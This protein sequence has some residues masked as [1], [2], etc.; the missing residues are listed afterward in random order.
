MAVKKTTLHPQGDNTTD[1][2]P[3]TSIDQV[4]GYVELNLRNGTNNGVEGGTSVSEGEYSF[5]FGFNSHTYSDWCVSM[6]KNC[7]S[8]GYCSISLGNSCVSG[9]IEEN[10]QYTSAVSMGE[11]CVA[12]GRGSVS[13]GNTCRVFSVSGVA[14]GNRCDVYND[15]G[16]AVGYGSISRGLDCVSI[17]HY[18]YTG[19]ESGT[20]YSSGLEG[21]TAVGIYNEIKSSTGVNRVMFM[22]GGGSD[23]SH[24]RNILEVLHTGAVRSN[25]NEYYT[26]FGDDFATIND[27]NNSINKIKLQ[28]IEFIFTTPETVGDY[29]VDSFRISMYTE[30][31]LS[32]KNSVY[33]ALKNGWGVNIPISVFCNVAGRR[34]IGYL[35][36]DSGTNVILTIHTDDGY[37]SLRFE[38]YSYIHSVS[39]ETRTLG[40]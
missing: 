1:L 8:F 7:Q 31:D 3:K 2:Y 29:T 17:G 4:E 6:G 11:S 40:D 39:I 9:S 21:Q 18:C 13:I 25:R 34:F 20:N 28:H 16:V 19:F 12:V 36:L 23:S 14:I 38:Y 33:Q 37:K 24:R 35:E 15:F 5:A 10:G 27:V 22:V 32:S 30:R 26:Q